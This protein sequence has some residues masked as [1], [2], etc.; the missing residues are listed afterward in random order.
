MNIQKQSSKNYLIQD[1]AVNAMAL[2]EQDNKLKLNLKCAEKFKSSDNDHFSGG[3]LSKLSKE[4]AGEIDLTEFNAQKE[5][6][7]QLSSKLSEKL[8][9]IA[10]KRTRKLSEHEGD[11]DYSRQWEIN[12]FNNTYRVKTGVLPVVKLNVVFSFSALHEAK[13]IAKYGAFT[14]AIFS[15]LEE[16]GVTCEVNLIQEINNL[17]Q[18]GVYTKFIYNVKNAGDFID[19]SHVARCF[20]PQFFRRVCFT[21]WLH[22]C[23]SFGKTAESRLGNVASTSPSFENGEITITIDNQ[24]DRVDELC[25]KIVKAIAGQ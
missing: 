19:Q 25:D 13:N 4:I 10:Q 11:W 21:H 6:I 5:K 1:S 16:A 14:W 18:E 3:A 22:F 17:F 20:T 2:F 8:E 24:A 12:P 23:E 7:T 15:R 9:P